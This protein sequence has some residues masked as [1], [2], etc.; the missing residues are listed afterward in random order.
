LP[1]GGGSAPV[2]LYFQDGVLIVPEKFATIKVAKWLAGQSDFV[3]S[4][5]VEVKLTHVRRVCFSLIYL[6]GFLNQ[7]GHFLSL[8]K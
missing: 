2:A 7:M 8:G 3:S 5:R 6:T 1:H 4:T